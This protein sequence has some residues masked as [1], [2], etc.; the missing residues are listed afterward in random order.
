MEQK[1]GEN[2]KKRGSWHLWEQR[3]RHVCHVFGADSQEIPPSKG[4]DGDVKFSLGVR[5]ACVP[6]ITED[7]CRFLFAFPV[8]GV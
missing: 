4:A 3:K 7:V 1:E 2:K 8:D 6:T 5:M